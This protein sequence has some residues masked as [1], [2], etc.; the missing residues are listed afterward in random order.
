MQCACDDSAGAQGG[1]ASALGWGLVV[2]QLVLLATLISEAARARRTIGLIRR[3]GILGAAAGGAVVG[4]AALKLG[5]ELR[6]HPAP[7]SG[8]V[9]RTDGPYRLVRHPIYAG[10]LLFAA[11][12]AATA[13]TARAVASLCGLAALLSFKARFEERLLAERFSEYKEYARRTPRFLPRVWR[14]RETR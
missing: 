5:R 7:P 14:V 13:G 2:L 9:L 10:L 4:L 3:V 1:G 11:G 8:A 12:S 6:A